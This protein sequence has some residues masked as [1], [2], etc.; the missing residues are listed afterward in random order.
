M[1][2]LLDHLRIF[3]P[4][5]LIIW[6]AAKPS[7]QYDLHSSLVG[8]PQVILWESLMISK[9]LMLRNVSVE[10]LSISLSVH[11]SMKLYI[12]LDRSPLQFS[13]FQRSRILTTPYRLGHALTMH[14]LSDAIFGAGWVVGSLELLGSP[15]GLARAMGTGLRDFISLPYQGFVQGP[16]AFLRG[17]KAR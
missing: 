9:P 3:S 11:S 4:A 15:G 14:Y 6:P 1:T 7:I 5:E 16:W 13:K 10:P 2:K 8:V 17:E 12:A